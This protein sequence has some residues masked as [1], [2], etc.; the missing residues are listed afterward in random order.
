MGKDTTGKN[1]ARRWRQWTETEARAALAEFGA[2]GESAAGFARRKGCS[3]QRIWY[4]KKRLASLA[5]PEFVAVP[6]P[7]SASDRW[8]EIDNGR[9]VVRV[10]EGLDVAHV[11]RVVGSIARQVGGAC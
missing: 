3:A 1:G 2:S 10:R 7:S 9:V 11:A 4:W 6:L 5:V 8:I